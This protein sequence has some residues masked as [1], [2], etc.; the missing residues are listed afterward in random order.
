[1]KQSVNKIISW[2]VNAWNALLL[3]FFGRVVRVCVF[4]MGEYGRYSIFKK[5]IQRYEKKPRMTINEIKFFVKILEDIGGERN[6]KRTEDG[7]AI[8]EYMLLRS[9]KMKKKIE[10]KGGVW[11]TIKAKK[12]GDNTYKISDDGESTIHVIYRPEGTSEEWKNFFNRYLKELGWDQITLFDEKD[13]KKEAYL[14]YDKELP[15]KRRKFCFLRSHSPGKSYP[16]DIKYVG[17]HLGV[18][19]DVCLYD[20]RGTY[21]SS[22]KPT[23]GGYYLDAEAVYEE[24]KQTYNYDPKD[25]WTTGF[26]L[27]GAV[28]AFL[29]QKYHHE[30]IN[31]AAEN[32]FSSLDGL[33]NT[34]C[35]LV[36]FVGMHGLPA[37]EAQDEEIISKVDQ[38]F[39]DTFKKFNSLAAEGKK[40][41]STTIIISTDKDTIVPSGTTKM[42]CE[43]SKKFGNNYHLVHKKE[44][45]SRIEGH[46]DRP[47]EDPVIRKN[48]LEIV[49][50]LE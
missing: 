34:Q 1:M 39:F 48:Y 22:G 36:V 49:L 13:Q 23:E 47:M 50:S 4:Q 24:L 16:L 6:K 28:A 31:Y 46:M 32:T 3:M 19:Y 45:K 26:S 33:I 29:K 35:W 14:T 41:P 25:I 44:H 11:K 7:E 42:L 38:D 37:I 8:I 17:I 27:G 5:I 43:T 9:E 20:Y 18:G 12:V 21:F 10:E 40:M 2:F 30:G 15:K